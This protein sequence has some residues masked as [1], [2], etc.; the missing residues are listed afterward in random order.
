MAQPAIHIEEQQPKAELPLQLFDL[1]QAK[2]SVCEESVA[3]VLGTSP[4]AERVYV[5]EFPEGPG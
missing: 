5:E 4:A 2:V 1:P 3:S